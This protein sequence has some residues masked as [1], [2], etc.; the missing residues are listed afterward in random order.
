MFSCKRPTYWISYIF[1]DTP[2]FFRHFDILKC[3]IAL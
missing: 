1:Y 2:S 3:Y